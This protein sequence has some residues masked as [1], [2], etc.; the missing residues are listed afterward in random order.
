MPEHKNLTGTDLH[1]PKGV[2]SAS[3]N[4]IY[5]A[6]GAGSG[7]WTY[8]PQGFGFYADNASAQTFNTTAAKISINGSAA[9]TETSYLPPEIRASGDLWDT[10]ND[11][12]TP[13]AL[14]DSYTFRM[15]IP[16]TAKT[17]S[18]NFI[19]VEIDIGGGATPSTVVATRTI[20]VPGSVPYTIN[21]AF[22]LFV[23]SD[24]L[25][26]GFQFFF[27]CD[28][29]TFDITAPDILISRISSGAL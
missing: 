2:A 4:Q 12:I 9:N 26:N 25:A 6:D 19:Y 20:S 8:I 10:S 27:S 14:G 11:K 7:A 16:V 17:G 1:E 29:G 15:D 21:F 18:P 23:S 3:E 22:P 5:V 28:T 13:I 24:A